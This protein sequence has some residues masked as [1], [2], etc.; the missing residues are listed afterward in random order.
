MRHQRLSRNEI[1]ER[2]P[3]LGDFNFN[4]TE[5]PNTEL[6]EVG[7]PDKRQFRYS[8]RGGVRIAILGET[9]LGVYMLPLVMSGWA[10]DYIKFSGGKIEPDETPI[11]AAIREAEEETGVVLKEEDLVPLGDNIRDVKGHAIYFFVAI[12]D[13]SRFEFTLKR[14]GDEGE[15]VVLIPYDRFADEDFLL[16]P[17]SREN[18]PLFFDHRQLAVILQNYLDGSSE[19]ATEAA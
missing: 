2:F 11:Q 6:A 18:P 14:E 17:A 4:R 9:T 15:I 1:R 3:F 13:V 12:I 8:S 16:G 19:K 10:A 7:S 5:E